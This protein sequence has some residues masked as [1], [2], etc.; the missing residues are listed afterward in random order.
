MIDHVSLLFRYVR[1][2]NNSL[3]DMFRTRNQHEE[4]YLQYKASLTAR[5]LKIFN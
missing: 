3:L 4:E 5:K 1:E 2:E